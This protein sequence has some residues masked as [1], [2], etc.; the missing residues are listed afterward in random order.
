M[1][2]KKQTQTIYANLTP[3][4]IGTALAR[5]VLTQRKAWHGESKVVSVAYRFTFDTEVEP[6]A[7]IDGRVEI[8]HS[9]KS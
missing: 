1:P 2:D 9:T 7:V 4:E 5:F 6:H 8:T 3:K